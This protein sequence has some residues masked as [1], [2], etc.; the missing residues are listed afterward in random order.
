M[1]NFKTILII[2]L[3]TL[4]FG[5]CLGS[6]FTMQTIEGLD[7]NAPATKPKPAPKQTP[8][9]IKGATPINASNVNS[10]GIPKSQI[11]PGQEDLYILKSQVIPPVC[12]ACPTTI[13]NTCNRPHSGDNE[14]CP[15]CPAC[16]RCP[17][18]A[19]ECKKVPT[20]RAANQYL[21]TLQTGFGGGP[22]PGYNMNESSINGEYQPADYYNLSRLGV[23]QNRNPRLDSNPI[24]SR[25]TGG[26][27]NR[28][29]ELPMPKLTDFSQF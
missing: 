19:F 11:A 14:T 10:Q 25:T 2:F 15:P 4:T 12:P 17:E 3:I 23:T 21:P 5:C 1:A 7:N 20:Y 22:L 26:I 29:N 24:I 8:S 27:A 6:V 16:A 18:P 28:S 13:V 9:S